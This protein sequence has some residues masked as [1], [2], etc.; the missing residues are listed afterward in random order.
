MI[1]CPRCGC[2][3]VW[4]DDGYWRCDG[5]GLEWPDQEGGE[6]ERPEAGATRPMSIDEALRILED[7]RRKARWSEGYTPGA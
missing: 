4:Y 5:C 6:P 2:T 1:T 3:D 7:V